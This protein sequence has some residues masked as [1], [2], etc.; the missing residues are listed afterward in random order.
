MHATVLATTSTARIIA[1]V[2]ALLLV[3]VLVRATIVGARRSDVATIRWNTASGMTAGTI[4]VIFGAMF[5]ANNPSGDWW[6]APFF[7]TVGV[8]GVAWVTYYAFRARAD[9][10]HARL[11]DVLHDP[12]DPDN[13]RLLRDLPS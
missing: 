9:R 4:C 2:G 3:P 6:Q 7:I 12:A 11:I 13:N 8:F 5:L 10:R 1:L